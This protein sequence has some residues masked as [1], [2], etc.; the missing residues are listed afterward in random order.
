MICQRAFLSLLPVVALVLQGCKPKPTP[1][2][3]PAPTPFLT[4]APTQAP[5]EGARVWKFIGEIMQYQCEEFYHGQPDG[6][7]ITVNT[8]RHGVADKV[9]Q[10]GESC[11][12]GV[13]YGSCPNTAA[14][15]E[16]CGITKDKEECCKS[17]DS[18]DVANETPVSCADVWTE[19]QCLNCQASTEPMN[20]NASL[21]ESNLTTGPDEASKQSDVAWKFIGE[22][23]E[24]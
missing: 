12:F 3:T 20:S 2:P 7:K 21:N 13:L 10:C 4:P 22:I 15:V 18:A 1:A 11:Q 5:T 6:Y 19:V 24:R 14:C 8:T 23:M 16:K 9:W 17:C